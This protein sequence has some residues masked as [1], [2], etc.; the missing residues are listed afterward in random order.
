MK[1]VLSIAL[2]SSLFVIILNALTFMSFV[3]FETHIFGDKTLQ[4]PV[5]L[6]KLITNGSFLSSV[7]FISKRVCQIMHGS[8][9][10]NRRFVAKDSLKLSNTINIILYHS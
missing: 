10:E 2:A 7:G 3:S 4:L 1:Y 8:S 9:F 6:Y 5:Y